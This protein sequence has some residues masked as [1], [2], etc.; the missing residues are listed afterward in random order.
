M[1]SVS[2]P[3]RGIDGSLI[4]W[5]RYALGCFVR[6]CGGSAAPSDQSLG[7]APCLTRGFLWAP[8]TSILPE[9][10]RRTP[11]DRLPNTTLAVAGELGDRRK[12]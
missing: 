8:V 9:A 6:V 3:S 2:C 1:S 12:R 7:R 10:N 5:R 4:S 11:A